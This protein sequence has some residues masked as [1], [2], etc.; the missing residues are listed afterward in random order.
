MA[1][2]TV[3][4]PDGRTARFG[5]RKPAA[6]RE[7]AKLSSFAATLPTPPPSTNYAAKAAS[8]LS[9]MYEN[10]QL[11]DCV[12][13]GLA[14]V[15]GVLISN[16]PATAPILTNAQ[17]NTIYESCGYVPG[18]PNTDNGC[19][20][21]Q[22]IDWWMENP[23]PGGTKPV[24]VLS[25]DPTNQNEVMLAIW[26][27]G[28][29]II[30]IDL[31]DAWIT[32]FPSANGFTWDVAGPPDESNGH[33]PVGVDYNAA[34]VVISTWAMTGTMTWAANAKYAVPGANGNA[35]VCLSQAML[36]KAQA[37]APNGLNWAQLIAY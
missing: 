29:L 11:G 15:D 34:G 16:Q 17:I 5:R 32:P 9:Q 26:L 36:I 6:L 31:P 28:N 13:A 24:G 10:D 22:T 23:L 20:V 30:G 14:H 21:L 4:R 1:I 3:T 19:E 12:P 7:I 33:C 27:F 8:V 2:K 37:K 25:V 35:F 18:N